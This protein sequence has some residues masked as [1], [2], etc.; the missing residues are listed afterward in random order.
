ML[1][2]VNKKSPPRVDIYF[3]NPEQYISKE[4][5]EN[6]EALSVLTKLK[7]KLSTVNK[8]VYFAC[9][10]NEKGGIIKYPSEED[11]KKSSK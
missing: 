6:Y 4:E 9:D 8:D 5:A 2:V 3:D 7:N 10:V 1:A 11:E